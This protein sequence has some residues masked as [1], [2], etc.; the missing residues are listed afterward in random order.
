V[1]RDRALAVMV[2]LIAAAILVLVFSRHSS[3][4]TV[5]RTQTAPPF[6]VV[7]P[8]TTPLRDSIRESAAQRKS[9]ATTKRP[10]PSQG[11][12]SRGSSGPRGATTSPAQRPTRK[13]RVTPKK[14]KTTAS[15]S[16]P[17]PSP[18]QSSPPPQSSNP[19]PQPGITVPLPTACIPPLICP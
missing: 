19:P 11:S 13:R 9:R 14:R 10:Q 17:A 16:T 15:P 8:T 7:A 1:T 5:E 3:T 12:A 2:L 4:K 18:Q 6:I